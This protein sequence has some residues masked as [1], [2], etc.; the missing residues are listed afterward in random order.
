M[1][2]RCDG[3]RRVAATPGTLRVLRKPQT[4]RILLHA[5]AC[6]GRV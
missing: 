4:V 6:D 3:K 1:S 2:V 5:T